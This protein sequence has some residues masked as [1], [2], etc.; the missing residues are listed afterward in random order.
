MIAE[1]SVTMA[2]GASLKAISLAIH[3][4]PTQAEAIRAAAEAALR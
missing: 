3:P 1:F 4:F 2:V